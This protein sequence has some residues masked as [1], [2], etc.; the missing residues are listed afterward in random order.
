MEAT[1]PP[2]M[3]PSGMLN[4]AVIND[5]RTWIQNGAVR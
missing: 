4:Q 5:I 3:P 2:V 1:V